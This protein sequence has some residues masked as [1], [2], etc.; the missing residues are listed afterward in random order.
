[1]KK[2]LKIVLAYSLALLCF[3]CYYDEFPEVIIEEIDD[4]VEVT[5]TNDILP[6]F[7]SYNCTQCHNGGSIN[8]DLRPANAYNSLIPTYVIEFNANDSRLFKK[9]VD[10]HNDQINFKDKDLVLIKAWIERGAENN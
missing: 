6:I 3:S 5:F 7:A 10:N 8:P 2:L 9:L 1:M 4:D